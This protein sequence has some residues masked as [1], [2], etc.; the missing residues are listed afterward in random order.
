MLYGWLDPAGAGYP[1]LPPFSWTL[2]KGDNRPRRCPNLVP[3][4]QIKEGRLNALLCFYEKIVTEPEISLDFI[5]SYLNMPE[6]TISKTW[7]KYRPTTILLRNGKVVLVNQK[8]I[9]S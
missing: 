3:L 4:R 7:E 9:I 8:S 1:E 2:E 5:L 6:K